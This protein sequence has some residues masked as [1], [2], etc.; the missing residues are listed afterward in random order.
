MIYV[1]P[2]VVLGCDWKRILI[3]AMM[4]PN[5]S[6]LVQTGTNNMT[7]RREP[8]YLST[9]VWRA[10]WILA[11]AA[12]SESKTLTVDEIADNVLRKAIMATNPQVFKHQK[13]VEK[14]E[15]ELIKTL[16]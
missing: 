1:V 14:L 7:I 13:Q 2:G 15:S 6:P 10:L 11:K 4:I 8:T 3:L 9:E 5:W 12:S 16:Q